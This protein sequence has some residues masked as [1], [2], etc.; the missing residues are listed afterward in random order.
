MTQRALEIAREEGRRE[1]WKQGL[2][3]GRWVAWSSIEAGR[4]AEE[5]E[6]EEG[7]SQRTLSSSPVAQSP[8]RTTR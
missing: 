5:D 8:P 2:E 4:R 3:R 6:D 7:D 1:G